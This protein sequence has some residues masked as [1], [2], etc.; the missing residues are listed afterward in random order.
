MLEI[1]PALVRALG[2]RFAQHQPRVQP[3]RRASAGQV[4]KP[5][6]RRPRY[7]QK[8]DDPEQRALAGDLFPPFGQIPRTDLERRAFARLP[9]SDE[10][11]DAGD[12]ERYLADMKRHSRKMG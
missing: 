6:D 11:V 5:Q 2:S 8:L 12:P 9:A 3:D 10:Q 4:A 1:P 7:E